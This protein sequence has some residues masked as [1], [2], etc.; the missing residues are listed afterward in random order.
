[1]VAIDQRTMNAVATLPVWVN[2]GFKQIT[3]FGRSGWFLVPLGFCTLVLAV[4]SPFMDRTG[5]TPV[6]VWLSVPVVTVITVPI[7]PVAIGI[8]R[9][10]IVAAVRSPRLSGVIV[11]HRPDSHVMITGAN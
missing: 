7:R 6:P 5:R 11:N 8:T 4:S 3:D 9:A 10:A 1:M 2:R